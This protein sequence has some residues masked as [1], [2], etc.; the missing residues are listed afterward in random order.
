MCD[1][2]IFIYFFNYSYNARK[3][4]GQFFAELILLWQLATLWNYT[5]LSSVSFG[6]IQ[7]R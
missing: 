5:S 7:L 4:I 2:Y 1:I 3:K 6:L